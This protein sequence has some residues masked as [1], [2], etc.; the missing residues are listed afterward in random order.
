[1]SI[2]NSRNGRAAQKPLINSLHDSFPL[3]TNLSLHSFFSTISDGFVSLSLAVSFCGRFPLVA[4]EDFEISAGKDWILC[5]CRL[6]CAATL[7]IFQLLFFWQLIDCCL[8]I[9]L[10]DISLVAP[11]KQ[12][13]SQGIND[14][15]CLLINLEHKK[16][17]HSS[18]QYKSAV[19]CS[20]PPQYLH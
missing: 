11:F 16:N 3:Q 17:G 2:C 7:F 9:K 18:W 5:W 12:S 19:H 15:V 4:G 6:T 8:L 1:M 14:V 20:Q 13:F 10:Q